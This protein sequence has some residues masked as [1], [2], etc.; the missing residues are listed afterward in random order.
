MPDIYTPYRLTSDGD[1]IDPPIVPDLERQGYEAAC[2]NDMT[3]VQMVA[4]DYSAKRKEIARRH[5][6]KVERRKQEDQ[7]ILAQDAERARQEDDERARQEAERAE[8]ERAAQLR[9]PEAQQFDPSTG[10]PT[11]GGNA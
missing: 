7:R 1:V 5:N 10:N 8:Q 2:A 11:N 3:Q 9:E 4:E 6:E